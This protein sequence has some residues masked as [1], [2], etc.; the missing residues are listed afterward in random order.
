MCGPA[1]GILLVWFLRHE[2]LHAEAPTG[3]GCA[4]G[5]C[6]VR[7]DWAAAASVAGL[8]QASFGS[9][10]H[11]QGRPHYPHLDCSKRHD[12]S[13]NHS[14]RGLNPHLPRTANE[15]DAVRYSAGRD[16]C[17]THGYRAPIFPTES[18]KIVH[19]LA[20]RATSRRQSFRLH[21]L[22]R[23]SAQRRRSRRWTLEP[24]AG[25]VGPHPSPPTGL[26]WT[27]HRSGSRTD[28]DEQR[29][30]SGSNSTLA[31][32]LSGVPPFGG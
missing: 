7:D 31:L 20:C 13:E 17:A 3:S 8:A 30:G 14:K 6:G 32:S 4:V 2:T 16:R 23:R 10:G 22:R 5:V 28:L 21:Y 26:R 12:R 18:P 27:R 25:F 19:R 9:A 29:S 15:V 1:R 24:G 11:T